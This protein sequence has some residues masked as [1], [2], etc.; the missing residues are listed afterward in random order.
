VESELKVE[1]ESLDGKNE[2]R[3]GSQKNN[4]AELS[5]ETENSIGRII[6]IAGYTG[7]FGRTSAG[8]SVL[9]DLI[10]S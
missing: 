8:R 5:G 9:H 10:V 1:G 3:K 2:E 6:V 7:R 4:Q